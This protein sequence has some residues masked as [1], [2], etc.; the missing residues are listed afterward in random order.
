MSPLINPG[1][2]TLVVKQPSYIIGD[3]ISFYTI[4]DDKVNIITHRIVN[5]GGNVYITKGDA[6]S[7]V[8]ETTVLPRLVI[9]KVYMIIPYLGL[10][11][12]F[13]KTG[14][15]LW[16]TILIPAIWIIGVE[17]YEIIGSQHVKL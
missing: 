12:S 6:N 16:L 17:I 11:I 7:A 8:D 1:S 9:G 3:I 13:A 2:I 10:F 15:G 4:T 14:I 5:A